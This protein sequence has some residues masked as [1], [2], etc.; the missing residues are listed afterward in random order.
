MNLSKYSVFSETQ[1]KILYGYENTIELQEKRIAALEMRIE[2]L[3]R[4][5]TNL[6]GY[7]LGTNSTT[8]DLMFPKIKYGGEKVP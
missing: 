2:Q 6:V 8:M 7:P 1:R 5:K 3:E 4:P